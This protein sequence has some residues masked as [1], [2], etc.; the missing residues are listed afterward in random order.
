M[1]LPAIH[2]NLL[3]KI[4]TQKNT[5]PLYI[6]VYTSHDGSV[7]MVNVPTWMVDA[8]AKLALG[9]YTSHMDG[10]GIWYT[11]NYTPKV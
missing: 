9:K 5:S 4:H 7:G 10:M 1:Q 3:N 6:F 2:Y 8:Y 11:H